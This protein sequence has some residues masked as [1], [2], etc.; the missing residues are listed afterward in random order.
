MADDIIF[1]Y[2]VFIILF[3]NKDSVAKR[4]R[5]IRVLRTIKKNKNTRFNIIPASPIDNLYQVY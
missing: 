3:L 5:E 1:S 2:V 4:E